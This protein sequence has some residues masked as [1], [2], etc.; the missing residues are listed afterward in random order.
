M[1]HNIC[2]VEAR[3]LNVSNGRVQ[4]LDIVHGAGSMDIKVAADGESE[5]INLSFRIAMSRERPS[6]LTKDLVLKVEYLD[7]S[8]GLAATLQFGTE[9]VPARLNISETTTREISCSYSRKI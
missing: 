5:T 8:S 1:T 3:D 9:E 7:E 6:I 2:K 4:E